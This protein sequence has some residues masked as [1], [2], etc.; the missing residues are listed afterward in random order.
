MESWKRGALK[1]NSVLYTDQA[2]SLAFSALN[3]GSALNPRT[4]NPGTTVLV[5]EKRRFTS[6]ENC[7]EIP[8][9]GA[10]KKACTQFCQGHVTGT[11]SP[12]SYIIEIEIESKKYGYTVA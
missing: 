8:H 5:E 3:P 6:C 11:I 9:L 2:P 10:A 7:T 12:G 4:L 1:P